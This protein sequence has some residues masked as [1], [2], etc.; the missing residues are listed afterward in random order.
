MWQLRLVVLGVGL[1]LAGWVQ[2]AAQAQDNKEK[3][4]EPKPAVPK[5]LIVNGKTVKQWLEVLE[6]SK[7]LKET[8][9]AAQALAAAGTKAAEIAPD[10]EK[11]QKDDPDPD[12]KKLASYVLAYVKPDGANKLTAPELVKIIRSKEADGTQRNVA[13]AQLAKLGEKAGETAFGDMV[14]TLRNDQDTYARALAAY[15]LPY[16]R[17]NSIDPARP[18]AD[19]LKDRSRDVARMAAASLV[20]M[21]NSARLVGPLVVPL[22]EDPDPYR[23]ALAAYVLGY[24]NPDRAIATPALLKLMTD[25]NENVVKAARD[26]I[27]KIDPATAKREGIN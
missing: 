3:K 8:R 6:K 15:V 27:K 5:E 2:Q 19:A 23:R 24:I 18:L 26:A 4:P 21:G 7:D 25:R 17:P 12:K 9:A 16:L 22:L 10:L 11:M 13:A 1:A 20:V 14:F